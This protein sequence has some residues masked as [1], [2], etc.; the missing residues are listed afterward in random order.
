MPKSQH[1]PSIAGCAIG[2]AAIG[3]GVGSLAGM[4][5]G[6]WLYPPLPEGVGTMDDQV[7]AV[8]G[9]VFLGTKVGAM[10][11]AVAGVL[12]AV[13]VRRRSGRLPN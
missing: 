7:R 8:Y 5:L 6:P 11:G 9:G 10:I 4:A 12:Y 1:L 3:C 2:F 13:T